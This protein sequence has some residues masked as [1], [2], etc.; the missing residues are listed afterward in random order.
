[1]AAAV[2]LASRLLIAGK[3]HAFLDGAFALSEL[4]GEFAIILLVFVIVLVG[5]ALAGFTRH[6]LGGGVGC[7]CV[8]GSGA[9]L[10]V[11]NI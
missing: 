1:M 10:G 11:L 4:T 7:F 3:V 6:S 5:V 9:L 8:N 2:R